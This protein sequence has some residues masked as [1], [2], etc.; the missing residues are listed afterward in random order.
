MTY[1]RKGKNYLFPKR[2]KSFICNKRKNTFRK[3][4]NYLFPKQQK[5]LISEKG[6]IS[7]F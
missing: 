3:S 7:Y 5:L 1:F 2:E 6:K 4:K